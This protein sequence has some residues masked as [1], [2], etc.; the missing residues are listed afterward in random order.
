MTRIILTDIAYM[1]MKKLIIHFREFEEQQGLHRLF[2]KAVDVPTDQL[3]FHSDNLQTKGFEIYAI[4]HNS[5][6]AKLTGEYITVADMIRELDQEGWVWKEMC[7][8]T[9]LKNQ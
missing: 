4:A 7:M 6:E 8:E 2:V 3:E 9:L 5:I 1:K